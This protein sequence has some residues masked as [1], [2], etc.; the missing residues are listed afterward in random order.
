MRWALL[1]VLFACKSDAPKLNCPELEKCYRACPAQGECTDK[2]D[3]LGTP[4][5]RAANTALMEC[6]AASKCA[7][8]PCMKAA[9]TL[10]LQACTNAQ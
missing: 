5:A 10:Q 2:C 9:C 7:D 4:A 6:Y 1:I 8:R 3:A